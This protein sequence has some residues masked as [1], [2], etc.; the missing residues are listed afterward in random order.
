MAP[1]QM[2]SKMV[3]TLLISK[4]QT[5]NH[6]ESKVHRDHVRCQ[7]LRRRGEKK[8]VCVLVMNRAVNITEKLCVLTHFFQETCL[9]H[10]FVTHFSS[11]SDFLCLSI[12]PQAFSHIQYIVLFFCIER[13]TKKERTKNVRPLTE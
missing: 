6:N 11:L 5:V 10:S 13:M 2:E 12:K 4:E 1:T 7:A 9:R 8:R 3:L